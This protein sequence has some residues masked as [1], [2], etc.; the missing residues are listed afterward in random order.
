MKDA[1]QPAPLAF[2][3]ES[4]TIDGLLDDE[5]E[6]VTSAVLWNVA[7]VPPARNGKVGR[8]RNQT[9][10]LSILTDLANENRARLAASGRSPD[11]ARV[12]LD[13]WRERLAANGVD[14]K[15]FYDL[16]N[17]LKDAGRIV[18][19]FGDY[20]RLTGDECPL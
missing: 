2:K 3:L 4:V 10:A 12:T 19:E 7:H 14:R 5:G 11:S 18:L 13:A 16:R 6:K 1:E 17:T 9:L 15:R 20:V 8:G